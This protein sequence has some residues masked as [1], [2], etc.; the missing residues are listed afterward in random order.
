M[1]ADLLNKVREQAVGEIEQRADIIEVRGL[2]SVGRTKRLNSL[3]DELIAALRYGGVNWQAPPVP[4]AKSPRLH[5]CRLIEHL[6][7][8][9]GEK[10][11]LTPDQAILLA[12]RE[13][14]RPPNARSRLKAALIKERC[15]KACGKLPSASPCGPVCSA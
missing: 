8:Q 15:V 6:N 12:L 7:T 3:F 4:A 2:R 11:P 1:L 10:L 14:H 9:I 5:V 13:N